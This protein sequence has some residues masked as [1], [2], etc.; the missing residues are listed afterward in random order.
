MKSVYAD[1]SGVWETTHAEEANSAVANGDLL[2]GFYVTQLA[3][4]P[5]GEQIPHYVLGRRDG[6][7]A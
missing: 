6:K 5:C 4:M 3:V 1:V 7:P 2:I